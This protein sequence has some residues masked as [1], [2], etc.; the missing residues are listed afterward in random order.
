MPNLESEE[1][2]NGLPATRVACTTDQK[3]NQKKELPWRGCK[4]PTRSELKYFLAVQ[5]MVDAPK[6][7]TGESI[8]MHLKDYGLSLVHRIS[9]HS[10]IMFVG[11]A[12]MGWAVF[13]GSVSEGALGLAARGVGFGL[14]ASVLAIGTWR[15]AK[16]SYTKRLEAITQRGNIGEPAK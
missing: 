4:L 7:P 16:W 14:V 2:R 1:H 12:G 8:G 15:L 3:L 9:A 13:G 6:V 5:G 10:T 11:L